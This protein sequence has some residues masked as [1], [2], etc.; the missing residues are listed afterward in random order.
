MELIKLNKRMELTIQNTYLLKP[1]LLFNT[2]FVVILF[3]NI[4]FFIHIHIFY[5]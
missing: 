3:F 4:I 2:L 5:V 1:I